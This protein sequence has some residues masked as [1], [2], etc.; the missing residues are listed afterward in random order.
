MWL[1]VLPADN[2][3]LTGRKG[4]GDFNLDFA[5]KQGKKIGLFKS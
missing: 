2:I 4:K 5:I 1:V 3:Y